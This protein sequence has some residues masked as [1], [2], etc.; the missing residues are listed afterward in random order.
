MERERER[1][2]ERAHPFKIFCL[3]LLK[4]WGKRQNTAPAIDFPQAE[5]RLF[6]FFKMPCYSLDNTIS[7]GEDGFYKYSGLFVCVCL[8]ER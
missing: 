2:R 8:K 3:F 6:S 1:E 4:V 5:A 7:P